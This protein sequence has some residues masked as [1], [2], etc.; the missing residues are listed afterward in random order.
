MT[1]VTV[2]LDVEAEE[3]VVRQ[4]LK[5]LLGCEGLDEEDVASLRHVLKMYSYPEELE[6]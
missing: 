6:L 1:P 5:L 4:S 2:E 3:H